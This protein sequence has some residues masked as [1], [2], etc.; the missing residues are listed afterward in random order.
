[1]TGPLANRPVAPQEPLVVDLAEVS[2]DR[3]AAVGGKA[4]NLGELIKSGSTF[5]PASV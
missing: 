2:A 5:R 4:A 3:L 1:M